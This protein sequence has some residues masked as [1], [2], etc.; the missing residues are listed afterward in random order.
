MQYINSQLL[1]RLVCAPPPPPLPPPA[2]CVR[3][4]HASKCVH[5]L[6]IPYPFNFV[7]KEQASQP[8]A[9]QHEN[10][11]HR[12]K[13]KQNQGSLALWLLAF[14]RGKASRISRA[15][16][17]DKKLIQSNDVSGSVTRCD[18]EGEDVIIPGITDDPCISCTCKVSHAVAV[19]SSSSLLSSPPPSS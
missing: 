17:W 14:S 16:H 3:V 6:K 10:T 15:W 13:T 5:T 2:S 1:C 11:A 9:W 4:R 8:V 7:V 12:R 18:K 19:S